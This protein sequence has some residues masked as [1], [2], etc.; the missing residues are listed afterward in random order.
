MSDHRSETCRQITGMRGRACADEPAPDM[1]VV[2]PKT[3][4]LGYS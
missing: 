1:L 2:H 4:Q 3:V